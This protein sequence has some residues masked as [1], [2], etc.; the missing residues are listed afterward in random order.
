[1]KNIFEIEIDGFDGG[2]VGESIGRG[3]LN[4]LRGHRLMLRSVQGRSR[5]VPREASIPAGEHLRETGCR[6]E[7][8]FTMFTQQN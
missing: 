2:S 6:Q 7:G 1:M 4:L 5:S 3:F 8:V